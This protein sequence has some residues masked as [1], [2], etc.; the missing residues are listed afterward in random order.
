M[1]TKM[2]REMPVV[3]ANRPNVANP[4]QA[5]DD[6]DGKGD[7]CDNCPNVANSDQADSDKDGKGDVCNNC[8]APRPS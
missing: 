1:M 2:E 8:P 7:V 4:D 6:K 5:D 3:S